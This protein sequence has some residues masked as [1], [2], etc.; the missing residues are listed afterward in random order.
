MRD[1][2]D[3]YLAEVMAHAR[4]APE[5]E[6]Q[7]RPELC[8]HLHALAASAGA[9]HFNPSETLAMLNEEFGDPKQIGKSIAASKGRFATFLKK[10]RR[11]LA[12]AAAI[13]LVSVLS[14]R[15]AVAEVFYV[16]TASASPMIPKGSHCLVYKLSSDYRPGDMIVFRTPDGQH[17]WL[18]TVKAVDDSAR[19]LTVGRNEAADQQVPR[20][21]VIGRVVLNTR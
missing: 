7:V 5:D 4:L 8:E 15:W 19:M 13:I 9:I 10:H 6:R 12:V 17:N 16:P 14:V 2:V 18:G 3:I 20:E 11:K 1:P 21:S